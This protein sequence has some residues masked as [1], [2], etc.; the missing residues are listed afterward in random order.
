MRASRRKE[1]IDEP[2]PPSRAIRLDTPCPSYDGP[3]ELA[4]KDTGS[5]VGVVTDRGGGVIPGAKV[6]VRDVDRGTEF[7]TTTDANGEYVAGP[8]KV[9]RYT[10]TVEKDKF[11]TAVAGP[12]QLDVQGRVEANV[13]WKSAKLPRRWK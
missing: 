10:V 8:L 5:I 1:N 2:L 9:G 6:T 4:Q 7:K 3:A 13:A 11:K 12:V